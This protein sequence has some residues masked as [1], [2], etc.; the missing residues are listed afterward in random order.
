MNRML[1]A[2]G[3]LVLTLSTLISGCTSGTGQPRTTDSWSGASSSATSPSRSSVAPVPPP[4]SR[5]PA[6]PGQ[7]AVLASGLAVAW[8]IAFLPDGSALVSE[9]DSHRI[10]RVDEHGRVSQLGTVP[11]VAPA[12]GEGG[13]LGLAASPA[14]A[15]DHLVYAYLTASSD[16]RVVRMSYRN[17]TLGAAQLVFAGIPKAANHDGGRIA[18]GPDG[19]LYVTTGDAGRPEGAPDRSY[20]GGK[21]LRMTP[22]G[23]PA[24]GNP[25]A[26]SVIFTLGHRNP[27]GLAWGPDGTLYEAEFGQ[28]ALDEINV[29]R[30][31]ADYGWPTVEGTIGP[32][33]PNLRPPLLTFAT[34]EASPSGLAFAGGVL[35]L[36]ALQGERLYQ[37]PLLAPG[38]LS[39]PT[40][41]LDH[42]YGRL[43][44]VTL[45]PDGALWITTSNRDGRGSPVAAD[46]RIIRLPLLG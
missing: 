2:I 22:D 7:A 29:L 15:T 45:A 10:V 31:G 32:S 36:A 44:T 20:L 30:P 37:I 39:T 24:A 42:Q 35:W 38:R 41:V 14:F 34:D 23:R 27:Q 21:V 26:G 6:H 5:A 4:T 12:A 3:L 9:R 1:G 11:G 28:H 18:F 13:L 43:R 40:A 19:M 33:R 25:F 17:G 46:D 8:G 16:N